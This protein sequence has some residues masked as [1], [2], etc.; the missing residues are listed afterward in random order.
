M[1]LVNGVRQD[2]VPAA[3][4]GLNY[5]DGVFET[6]AVRDGRCLLWEEHLARLYDSLARLRFAAVPDRNLLRDEASMLAAE[7]GHGVLKIVVTRGSGRRGYRVTGDESPN[8]VIRAQPWDASITAA[9]A[10]GVSVRTCTLR[11]MREPAA[12]AAIK[13]LNRLPLVLA[14]MEW[15]A[16]YEEGLLLDE[17]DRLV[18][19]T[20]S[21]VFLVRQG[22]LV[23]PALDCCGIAGTMRAQVLRRAP[24]LALPVETRTVAAQETSGADEIFLTNSIIGIWPVRALDGR[25]LNIG[26]VTRA[27]QSALNEQNPPLFA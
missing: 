11:L 15:N 16:E 26:P 23:T 2:C 25:N 19:G 24:T 5:G 6:I 20:M 9:R 14:R 27:L 8:R 21:N 1:I 13:H 4:R 18:E 22:V 7:I 17:Q 12:L 3:D 10:T